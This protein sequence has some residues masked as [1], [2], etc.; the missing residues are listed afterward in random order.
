MNRQR[1][2]AFHNP[3][4]HTTQSQP[5]HHEEQ[6]QAHMRSHNL[7]PSN[8]SVNGLTKRTLAIFERIWDLQSN[9]VLGITLIDLAK[10]AEIS[11]DKYRTHH[12]RLLNTGML[13]VIGRESH[14]Y[15]TWRYIFKITRHETLVADEKIK[16]SSELFDSITSYRGGR[17][18]TPKLRE[19][20][21][22]KPHMKPYLPE[23]NVSR[24]VNPL[25]TSSNSSSSTNVFLFPDAQAAPACPGRTSLAKG[26]GSNSVPTEKELTEMFDECFHVKK[27]YVKPREFD[28]D[29]IPRYPSSKVCP[30]AVFPRMAPLTEDDN[31]NPKLLIKAYRRIIRHKYKKNVRIDSKAI[32]RL[33]AAGMAMKKHGIRSPDAWSYFR[34]VDWRYAKSKKPPGIDYI[35][36]VKVIEKRIGFFKRLESS[37][38]PARTTKATPSHKKLVELWNKLNLAVSSNNYPSG[39][40]ETERLVNS[41]L[42]KTIYDQLLVAANTERAHIEYW[43]GQ[44]RLE[45][46]WIWL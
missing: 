18:L 12:Q 10:L 19:L 39:R 42:P 13:E 45:G 25:L 44:R 46:E 31:F 41:I 24:G 2:R 9:G 32:F 6:K 35:F 23:N 4:E 38:D 43:A 3:Y 21:P 37:L 17:E 11:A 15:G 1:A 26:K 5:P 8:R 28:Q 30:F 40:I 27:P 34:L 33:K 36:S 22:P 20:T 29:Q 14:R 16:K 7:V